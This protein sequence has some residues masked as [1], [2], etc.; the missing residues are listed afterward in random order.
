MPPGATALF[1]TLI[2]RPGTP[3]PWWSLLAVDCGLI[4]VLTDVSKSFT[5]RISRCLW[6]F[7]QAVV[8]AH[9]SLLIVHLLQPEW[10]DAPVLVPAELRTGLHV[11][12]ISPAPARRSTIR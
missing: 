10:F 1:E 9:L 11:T 5:P 6:H 4:G 8:H 12:M 7:V 2:L 3:F